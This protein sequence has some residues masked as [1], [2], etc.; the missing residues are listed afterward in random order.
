MLQDKKST[1]LL[2]LLAGGAILLWLLWEP[3][4]TLFAD[5]E[6]LRA[7]VAGLGPWGPVAIVALGVIQVLVAPLPGYPVV[8]VSGALFG[9]WW[10]AIYANLGI[11]IAGMTAALLARTFGR[12]LAERF[13]ER[14]ELKRL[15]RLLES[16][17]PWLWFFV[18]LL[19]TGDLP[20]FAAGLSHVSMRNY[21]VALL[22]ARIPFTFLL[23][24]AAARAT[25]LPRETLILLLIPLALLGA[26]AYWQQ[27]RIRAWIHHSLDRLPHVPTS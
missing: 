18:L 20:Y 12:P 14:A 1:L 15:E 5:W 17:N 8:F 24:H 6:T 25:T 13:V 16:D 19:P 11:L 3:L 9:G 27:D 21:F 2:A 7:W 26:L 4:A 23:T 22:A 10:G